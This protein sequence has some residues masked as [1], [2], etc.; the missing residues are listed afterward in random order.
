LD[1]APP[2]ILRATGTASQEGKITGLSHQAIGSLRHRPLLIDPSN[3][4]TQLV[5][6]LVHAHGGILRVI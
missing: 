3:Q 5:R 2:L 1:L 6:L 4:L